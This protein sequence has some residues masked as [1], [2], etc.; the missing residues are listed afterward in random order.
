MDFR[1][2]GHLPFLYVHTIMKKYIAFILSGLLCWTVM[3]YQATSQ[4]IAQIS[5]LK[6]QFDTITT[7]SV[8]NK[9]NFYAQLKTLQEQFTGNEKL[10]YYLNELGL[11]LVAQVN[12][13]KTKAKT[14]S[15][16]T[17]QD[18]VNQYISWLSQDITT[19]DT[20]TGWYN[21]IDTI[22]FANNF[23]TALT[24]ATRYREIN[25]GYYMPSNGN[26]PFQIVS[27]DYGTGQITEATFIKTIQDF[28][29]FSKAKH[30]Q[31]TTKLWIKLTYTWFTWTGLVNHAA[32]YNGGIITWNDTSWYVAIPNNPHYVYDG[33]GQDYSW[34]VRY[35]LLPKFL[36]VLDWELKNSY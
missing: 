31:Y 15:K 26:G 18:F 2:D 21:T 22:S 17:K 28:I 30:L 35:G 23:P 32:L 9:W 5:S 25:C 12:T 1:F 14:M 8:K 33:Y 29:D 13:E 24:I 27:K 6:T 20:C 16:T 36:K 3:A 11:Y 10:N 19:A 7:G 34:A 4:D